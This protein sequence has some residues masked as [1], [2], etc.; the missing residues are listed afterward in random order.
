[1]AFLWFPEGNSPGEPLN[2]RREPTRGKPGELGA[3]VQDKT[4]TG[5]YPPKNQ[6]NPTLKEKRRSPGSDQG[7]AKLEPTKNL[8]DKLS[9]ELWNT[10][11]VGVPQLSTPR[12]GGQQPRKRI[13]ALH[14]LEASLPGGAA[15][16]EVASPCMPLLETKTL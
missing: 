10:C 5:K 8:L 11:E 7:F 14:C 15:P 1:V 3:G 2:V 4:Y 12:F 16:R 6:Q 13:E 9:V